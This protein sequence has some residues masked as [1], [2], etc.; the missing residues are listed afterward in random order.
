MRV[1]Q[2]HSIND[3]FK[4]NL[5]F[6]EKQEATNNL[7]IGIPLSMLGEVEK[8]SPPNLFSVF[9]DQQVVFSCVQTSPRNFLI[10]GEE[11]LDKVVFKSLIPVLVEKK[12]NTQGVIGPKHLAT[13]FAE[14]WKEETGQSWAINFEQ[15]I[16][17]LDAVREI[18]LSNGVF[19]KATIEDL[20]VVEQWFVDFAKEAMNRPNDEESRKIARE[21]VETG[22]LYLWKNEEISVSMAAVARPT[23]NGITVNYVYTPPEHRGK[24]Y[25]CSCVAMT[26]KLMLE[27]YKFCCLFTDLSN[28]SSNYIYQKIGY[29]PI[30]AY[31]EIRFL[32]D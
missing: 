27:E 22:C 9:N 17:Q 14:A 8:R 15:M 19:K 4:E 16:Y 24:G 1:K 13:G 31:R 10:Y 30:I 5:S 28:V 18:K 3:F 2:Y 6:L 23:R 32:N 20:P 25:A 29:Y 12:I 11:P 7:Q 21:K 26:S